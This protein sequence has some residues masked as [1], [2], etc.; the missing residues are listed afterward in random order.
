MYI[1]G[2]V[3]DRCP[4]DHGIGGWGTRADILRNDWGA[5]L[6]CLCNGGGRELRLGLG[7]RSYSSIIGA[8]VGG[9]SPNRVRRETQ[10]A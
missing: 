1:A 3:V 7:E 5:D 9:T 2:S 8:V 6:R 4:L 10:A